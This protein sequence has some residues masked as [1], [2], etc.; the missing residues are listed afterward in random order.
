MFFKPRDINRHLKKMELNSLNKKKLIAEIEYT[1]TSFQAALDRFSGKD[2]NIVPFKGSWTAGQV[3]EHII[4]SNGG[5]IRELSNGNSEAVDRSYDRNVTLM[6]EIFRDRNQKS[7]SA[8]FLEPGP[9]KHKHDELLDN[10]KNHKEQLLGVVNGKDLTLL[11]TGLEFP[12]GVGQMTYYEWIHMM[13]EHTRR[14][15]LQIE[16]IKV[17]V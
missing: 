15:Q 5:I 7:K 6:Q 14:H 2:L 12:S 16:D 13:I 8:T 1:Y 4:K 3:A 17:M 9:P 11:I 10:L